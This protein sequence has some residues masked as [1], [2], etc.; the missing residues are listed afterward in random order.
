[1]LTALY[2]LFPSTIHPMVIHFTIAINFLATL[3]GLIGFFRKRDPF[4]ERMYIWLL[5]LSILA[6]L[7]AGFTGVISAYYAQVPANLSPMFETHQ[8]MGELT[9]IAL[10]IAFLFQWF[11]RHNKKQVAALALVFS[12]IATILVSITGHL[13]G[14]MVY[15]HGLGVHVSQSQSN[16]SVTPS[17]HA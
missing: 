16:G 8:H 7:A 12:I 11:Y 2:H 6:T 10:V 3:I 15:S 4:Y 13:G 1:M 14:T 9:G 17:H 5:V